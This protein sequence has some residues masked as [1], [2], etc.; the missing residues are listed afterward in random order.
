MA[1]DPTPRNLPPA[2]GPVYLVLSWPDAVRVSPRSGVAGG[3]EG[4]IK[5]AKTGAEIPFRELA[6]VFPG[7]SRVEL[8]SGLEAHKNGENRRSA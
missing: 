4:Q 3:G 6:T 2:Q 5:D 1:Q 7:R 8:S